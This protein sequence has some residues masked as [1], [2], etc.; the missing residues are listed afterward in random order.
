MQGSD[1]KKT[2]RLL[3]DRIIAVL[4]REDE[5]GQIPQA[6]LE[7]MARASLKEVRE[8]WEELRRSHGMEE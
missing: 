8:F 2:D 5:T 7:R 1:M 4:R 3:L 6:Q